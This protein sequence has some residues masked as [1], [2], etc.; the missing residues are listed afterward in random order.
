MSSGKMDNYVKELF[1]N[2]KQVIDF[3]TKSDNI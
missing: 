2:D 3:F 1:E